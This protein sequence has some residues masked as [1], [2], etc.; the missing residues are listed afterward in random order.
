MRFYILEVCF[1]SPGTDPKSLKNVS[2]FSLI[3]FRSK[4][5]NIFKTARN[6]SGVNAQKLLSRKEFLEL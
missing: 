3:R 4:V 5:T 1:F 2:G 6:P